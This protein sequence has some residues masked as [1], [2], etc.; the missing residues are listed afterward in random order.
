MLWFY[1]SAGVQY[2]PIPW[3]ELYSLAS[4]G[5]LL[6]T[7][8]VWCDNL[9]DWQQA[10][11][12][13]G[14][15]SAPRVKAETDPSLKWILPVGRSSWAIAAGYLGLFSVILIGAPFAVFAGIIALREIKQKPELGGKGRAIF[16]IAMGSIFSVLYG[17]LIAMSFSRP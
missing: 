9:P 12:T 8:L 11:A 13:P 10:G 1:A 5:R 16:G 2:G 15:F 4:S 17:L 6:P 14:L 7:D 3:E